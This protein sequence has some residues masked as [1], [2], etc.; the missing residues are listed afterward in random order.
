MRIRTA[1][2]DNF[3][4][5]FGDLRAGDLFRTDFYSDRNVYMKLHPT[6]GVGKDGEEFAVDLTDSEIAADFD[7]DIEVEKVEGE[8]VI[9]S[10]DDEEDI[11][12]PKKGTR[13]N[14]NG[15]RK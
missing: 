2:I 5:K 15:S 7:N 8:L 1:K 10:V 11:E 3:K 9:N 14:N 4:M 12:E 6:Y 13:G